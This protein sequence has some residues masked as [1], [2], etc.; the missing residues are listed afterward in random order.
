MTLI[1]RYTSNV[2]DISMS[3]LKLDPALSD[4]DAANLLL[5]D[6]KSQFCWPSQ[7]SSVTTSDRLFNIARSAW[8]QIV[9]TTTLTY[10]PVTGRLGG[11]SS[12]FSAL[13]CEDASNQVFTNTANSFAISLWVFVPATH[14]A[15][16][17]TVDDASSQS[18]NVATRSFGFYAGNTNSRIGGFYRAASGDANSLGNSYVAPAVASGIHRYG[19]TW[20]KNGG[21]WQHRGIL[22]NG[23]PSVWTNSTFGT[24]T[25]GV[26]NNTAWN[27]LIGNA[28]SW[29]FCRLMIE[30]LTLSGRTSDQFWAADWARASGRFS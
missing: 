26:Q 18:L 20:A 6:T 8:P 5:I 29:P 3:R 9:P 16:A 14:A 19:Y 23:V 10:D 4:V 12:N 27:L 25:P 15:N 7:A 30:D 28:A 24:G 22:N 13:T 21:T 1:K 2:T 11:G 17:M